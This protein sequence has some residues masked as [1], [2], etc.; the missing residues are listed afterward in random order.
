[1]GHI[2]YSLITKQDKFW[3][4]VYFINT[5]LWCK[6]ETN[7]IKTPWFHCLDDLT[8]YQVRIFLMWGVSTSPGPSPSLSFVVC[9]GRGVVSYTFVL[10]RLVHNGDTPRN[11]SPWH[12]PGYLTFCTSLLNSLLTSIVQNIKSI[13][14]WYSKSLKASKRAVSPVEWFSWC[15]T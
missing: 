6:N 4:F 12:M 3:H 7:P 15:E 5:L 1:M 9:R 10:N 14:T 8:E 11:T 13:Y 2:S